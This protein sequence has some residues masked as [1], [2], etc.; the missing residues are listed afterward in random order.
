MNDEVNDENTLMDT[1]TSSQETSSDAPTAVPSSTATATGVGVFKKRAKTLSAKKGLRKPIATL[2]FTI[3]TNTM[4]DEDSE[5]DDYDDEQNPRTSVA[6]VGRKRKRG[7]SVQAASTRPQALKET[8]TVTYD[9]NRNHENVLDPKNQAT[10]TS[11]EFDD[12][13]LLSRTKSS[14]TLEHG[15]DNL[16][17]GQ[18]NY[19]QLIPKREQVTTK[20]NPMGPQKAASNIRMTTVVDYAP[21]TKPPL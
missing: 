14:T 7:G 21:G 4:S 9:A 16:Y 2:P 10:A 13:Q 5:E 17:R 15:L 11:A 6:P 8:V 3:S 12:D 19:R 1:P 20:Y 18:K